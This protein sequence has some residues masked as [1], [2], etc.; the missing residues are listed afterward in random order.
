ML[1]ECSWRAACDQIPRLGR[2]VFT[3]AHQHAARVTHADQCR[4]GAAVCRAIF[5]TLV[6]ECVVK[7]K[8]ARRVGSMHMGRA[9]TVNHFNVRKAP[10][11][12]YGATFQLLEGTLVSYT[13]RKWFACC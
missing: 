5:S 10:L 9:H 13:P 1:R 4:Y 8:Q 12:L 2:T 7:L 3:S 6:F 11:A